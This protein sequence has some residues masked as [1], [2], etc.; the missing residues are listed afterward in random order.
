MTDIVSY[1]EQHG[2]ENIRIVAPMKPN[3]ESAVAIAFAI[4][5][6]I[7]TTCTIDSRK[8]DISAGYKVTLVSKGFHDRDYYIDD[9]NNLIATHPYYNLYV[10]D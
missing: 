5:G 7:P 4:D 3:G 6:E 8:Y 9:L 10:E 1:A 2:V